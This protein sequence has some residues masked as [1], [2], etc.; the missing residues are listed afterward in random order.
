M[1]GSQ[2]I[3]ILFGSV[4]LVLASILAAQTLHDSMLKTIMRMPMAFFDTTPLG[5]ILNR[6]SKDIYTIDEAIPQSVRMFIVIC[7]SV[8]STLIVIMVA[9]PI[10][11]I[12]I[13]PLAF[14]YL[15]VQVCMVISL[16]EC[17]ISDRVLH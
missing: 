8:I 12:V 5:R 11:A 10:F 7:L 3:F 17:T 6:F 9:T 4:S 16:Y 1:G 2:A 13:I 15:L 14:L